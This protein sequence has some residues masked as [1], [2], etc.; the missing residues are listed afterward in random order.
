M[1]RIVVRAGLV[2]LLAAAATIAALEWFGDSP[3]M[4]GLET[5]SLDM[6]LR[7]RGEKP[8][9]AETVLIL[10]DDRSLAALGRW[11]FSRR[12][13]ARAI[14]R[15]GEAG[16]R[17][18]VLDLLFSE[19]EQPVSAEAREAARRAALLLADQ[20]HP[21]LRAALGRIADDD[22]DGTLATA[23]RT[24][25]RVML[26][27]AFGFQTA[28]G[29]PTATGP[30]APLPAD[31]A[32]S[33]FEPSPEEAEFP[34]QPQSLTPPTAQLAGEAAGLGHVTI[35]FDRDGAPRYEYL[36]LPYDGDLYPSLSV[37]AVAR[38]RGVAWSE[39]GL[40]PGHGVSIG[41]LAVPTDRSM[42]LLINYRGPRGTFPTYSFADLIEGKVPAA[43][44]RDRIALVGAAATGVNDTFR[45][46]YGSAP[47]P[48]VERMANA[49][50]TMLHRR[51][52]E[53]PD[54]L[55][56]AE[57]AAVLALAA[58]AGGV[59]AIVPA[60]TAV[61]VGVAPAALW[62]VASYLAVLNGLWL[63]LIIPLLALGVAML[64]V[65]LF[66]HAVVDREGRHVR[67]AFR[68][69][70]APALVSELAAHPE[71]L[72]LGG[73][74]RPMTVMFCD[75]RNFTRLSEGIPPEVLVQVVNRFF[76]PMTDIIQAHLGTVDK[77]I[78]DCVMAFWNAP[79]DDPDHARHAC[80]A[81][82]AMLAEIGQLAGRLSAEF[83]GV[84][85]LAAGIGLNSGACCVGNV[86]SR[87]RFDYSVLGDT[88]NLA[89]RIEGSCKLYGLP[90]LAGEATAA[91][92]PELPWLVV[93]EI[94]VRGHTAPTRI[95][96]LWPGPP[97]R[98]AA[99]ASL[100]ERLLAARH[101]E[102]IAELPDIITE[103]ETLA[104]PWMPSLYS[105]LRNADRQPSDIAAPFRS[106]PP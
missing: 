84:P 73:E 103:A 55:G 9:G 24:S 4:R 44:L 13:F 87:H 62:A 102:T 66:R 14:D 64:A 16:A 27:F 37:R 38:Y 54:L 91:L 19:P 12:L 96:A 23:L 18:I 90:L 71:R 98:H 53:R 97:E 99:L 46:P 28:F 2:A 59:A 31:T 77:Y 49:I 36:A 41:P 1:R 42:R 80:E 88:V 76:T 47:V 5:A 105:K 63:N 79:L 17:V 69:Y 29:L 86:G 34:L 68:H 94:T 40:A 32:F 101:G 8:P 56:A 75:I 45:T 58:L 3:M 67:A 51:F 7:L 100:H 72:R 61:L 95:Y 60:W 65:L 43:A 35:A 15:L 93:D 30:V 22:P 70:L 48:G 26:A 11:P 10:V 104:A 57:P 25:G 50:D 52:I 82:Q 81:A 92:A 6:R 89:S 33:R 20:G 106:P 85:H 74:I 83:P 21:E 39:V 78:G